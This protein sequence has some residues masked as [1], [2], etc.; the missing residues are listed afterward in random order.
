M[1]YF[2]VA[3]L[4]FNMNLPIFIYSIK[5]TILYII[6]FENTYNNNNE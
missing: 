2:D 1:P 4:L 5:K 3:Y 6:I